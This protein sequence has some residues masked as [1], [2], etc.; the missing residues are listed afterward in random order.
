MVAGAGLCLSAG[1][2][3]YVRGR[4]GTTG[5]DAARRVDVFGGVP[6]T[7]LRGDMAAKEV[8]EMARE[9]RSSEGATQAVGCQRRD[10]ESPITWRRHPET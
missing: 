6:A 5:L 4:T 9:G 10:R 3:G 2:C 1:R 8:L 7:P